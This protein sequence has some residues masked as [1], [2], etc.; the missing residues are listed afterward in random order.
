[1]L[2]R[3]L[4]ILTL[5][6]AAAAASAAS[7]ADSPRWEVVETLPTDIVEPQNEHVEVI[8][9]DG[10][11]YLAAPRPTQVKLFTILGQTV[12]QDRLPAGTSRLRLSGRG[13]YILKA[14]SFTCR[15]TI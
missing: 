4:A 6:L 10:A 7:P 14:G 3:L 8:V 1:M 13:I 12:A 11:I 5:T 9:R 2:T 15:V